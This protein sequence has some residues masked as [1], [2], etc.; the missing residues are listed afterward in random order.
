MHKYIYTHGINLHKLHGYIILY[1][2]CLKLSLFLAHY[3]GIETSCDVHVQPIESTARALQK[4]SWT[5]QR[6]A[7]VSA[8][9]PQPKTP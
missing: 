2:G 7:Q 1:H 5:V 9:N 6:T 4:R 3:M 8:Q